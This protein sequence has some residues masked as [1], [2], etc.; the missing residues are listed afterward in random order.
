MSFIDYFFFAYYKYEVTLVNEEVGWVFFIYIWNV[1]SSKLLYLHMS[2]EWMGLFL[3]EGLGSSGV[4]ASG[5]AYEILKEIKAIK[6][7]IQIFW[8]SI[9]VSQTLLQELDALQMFCWSLCCL[10]TSRPPVS[11]FHPC[12]YTSY[13][14]PSGVYATFPVQGEE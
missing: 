10:S 7:L 8:R 1:F 4:D 2:L 5:T 14:M 3:Q 6:V 11:L 13:C 9:L 12:P